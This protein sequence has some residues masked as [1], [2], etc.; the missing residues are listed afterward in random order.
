MT[1]EYADGGRVPGQRSSDFPAEWTERHA[2]PADPAGRAAWIASNIR[3]ARPLLPGVE[4]RDTATNRKRT[5]ITPQRARL[6]LLRRRLG[7]R[8]PA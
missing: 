6:E 7:E 5:P 4:I 8:P 3:G 2:L 1:I